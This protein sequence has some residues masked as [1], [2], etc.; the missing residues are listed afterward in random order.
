MLS[1]FY[2][3]NPNDK[4]WWVDGLVD[5]KLLTNLRDTAKELGIK[6]KNLRTKPKISVLLKILISYIF[7]QKKRFPSV[8]NDR[9]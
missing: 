6:E 1:D 8:A 3:N 4:I 7:G 2:K 9:K 5:R